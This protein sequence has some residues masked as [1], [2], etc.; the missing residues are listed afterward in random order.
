MLWEA[1]DGIRRVFIRTV[2]NWLIIWLEAAVRSYST[3]RTIRVHGMLL[4]VEVVQSLV[5]K[6]LSV[7]L[8]MLVGVTTRWLRW[9]AK[10]MLR[11]LLH[12]GGRRISISVIVMLHL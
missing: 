7:V 2:P 9:G 1:S 6:A 4:M 11:S 12:M 10:G 8:E 5:L 3:S